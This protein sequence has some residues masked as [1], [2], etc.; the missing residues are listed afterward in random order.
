MKK[1]IKSIF[2][3]FDVNLK[4]FFNKNFFEIFII[5]ISKKIDNID[6]IKL[7][8]NRLFNYFNIDYNINKYYD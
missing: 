6:F 3:K 2:F 8:Y 1:K 7:Y 5:N 4:D